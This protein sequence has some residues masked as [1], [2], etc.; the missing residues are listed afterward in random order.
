MDK[1]SAE[2]GVELDELEKSY[3]KAINAAATIEQEILL[4]QRQIIDLQ[5]KKKDLEYIK[6]KGTQNLRVIASELRVMKNMFFATRNS[7]L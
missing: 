1:T 2:I 6:S 3:Q 7:G 5:G 4:L